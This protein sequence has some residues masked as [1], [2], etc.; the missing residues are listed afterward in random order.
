MPARAQLI[1]NRAVSMPEVKG[2]KFK[3][4]AP[5]GLRGR[6][7]V[8]KRRNTLL[9]NS[10]RLFAVCW[11]GTARPDSGRDSRGTCGSQAT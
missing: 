8:S 3:K 11:I 2:R 6:T 7:G 4:Y 5:E 1:V 9:N 10:L